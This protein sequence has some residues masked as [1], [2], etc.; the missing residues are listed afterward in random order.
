MADSDQLMDALRSV[1]MA[2]IQPQTRRELPRL[3]DSIDL[4]DAPDD[5]TLSKAK[6]IDSRLSLLAS[7]RVP[8]VIERLLTLYGN[9]LRNRQRFD[10][11]ELLWLSN[12]P[13]TINRK[14]RYDLARALDGTNLYIKS[15]AFLQLLDRY[16]ILAEDVE[17]MS[18][19]RGRLFREIE[20][21]VIRNPEDWPV[22]HLFEK[23]GALE[24]SDQRFAHFIEGLAS[25]GVRPDDRSQRDF[26]TT[27]NGALTG[28]GVELREVDSD[29][30]YPVFR[31]SSSSRSVG[32]PKNLIFASS[33]KPDLR[34]RDAINNDIEILSSADDVLVYDRP[35]S[36]EGLRWRNLQEWWAETHEV[37]AD[38]AKR[39][40]YKR[41]RQS[42]PKNSPPQTLLFTS[43]FKAY[44]SVVYDLPALLPEVW[45]HW[46][47]K[48]VRE[49]GRAALLQHRMDFLLLMS[50]DVRV[51]IEVDGSHHYADEQHR[52]DP[53]RYAT[54]M[55]ADRDLRLSGYDV[56]RFGAAEL[57]DDSAVEM[58]KEFFDRLFRRHG[59]RVS[60]E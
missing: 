52:A 3:C 56:Y 49:R 31:F 57:Q 59:L 16:W 9:R 38:T 43:F 33:I 44:R 19:E 23:L 21:H 51:V 30:G 5:P 39:G 42:L 18:G 45:L 29:G 6:Y 20:Q 55:R 7:A 32:R 35:I 53:K 46:D 24:C 14:M 12:G 15:E 26:V 41:L 48:T 17:A 40:L 25:P 27:V 11:E 50:H 37:D 2:C 34:F 47:P 10:I 28:T 4:P 58:V 54:M 1:V 8:H 22:E 60:D 36:A 13:F